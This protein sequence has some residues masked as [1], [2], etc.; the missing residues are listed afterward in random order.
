MQLYSEAHTDMHNVCSPVTT[1]LPLILVLGIS[2]V[3][4]A[5]EDFNRYRADKALN[6]R[7][8]SV[9][10][11]ATQSFVEKQWQQVQVRAASGIS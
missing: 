7:M 6:T 9:F 1:F 5:V 2:M 8:V 4:E 3:K 11:S 10:S